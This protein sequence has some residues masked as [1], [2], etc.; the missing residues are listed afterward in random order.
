MIQA[1]CTLSPVL[2]GNGVCGEVVVGCLDADEEGAAP[3]GAHDLPREEP[4][5][6]G[7]REGALQLLDEQFHELPAWIGIMEIFETLTESTLNISLQI[8]MF[9]ACAPFPLSAVS[10]QPLEAKAKKHEVLFMQ[11]NFLASSLILPRTV[12]ISRRS[13]EL[14]GVETVLFPG[15]FNF[16]CKVLWPRK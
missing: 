16:F 8:V 13:A 2:N 3:T 6:E 5:L 7:A 10:D 9:I 11:W 12:D 4:R 14:G 15:I 1:V